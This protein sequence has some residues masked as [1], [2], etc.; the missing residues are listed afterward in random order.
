ML[1]KHKNVA[2]HLC[3]FFSVVLHLNK[4]IDLHTKDKIVAEKLQRNDKK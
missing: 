2:K 4:Q 1:I 3:Q